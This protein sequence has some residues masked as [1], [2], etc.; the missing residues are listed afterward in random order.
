M[1][2]P[3]LKEGLLTYYASI[4]DREK[5][6]QLVKKHPKL[7]EDLLELVFLK[8]TKQRKHCCF[9]GTGTISSKRKAHRFCFLF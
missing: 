5:G 8:R 9:M 1:K 4:E 3:N 6:V 2:T 7:F